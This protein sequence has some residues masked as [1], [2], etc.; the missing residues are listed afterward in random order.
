LRWW[1]QAVRRRWSEQEKLKIREKFSCRHCEKI[2][3]APAVFHAVP[4]G[5]AGQSL[6]AVIVFEKFG[7]LHPLN[8]K[9]GAPL[10]T[11]SRLRSRSTPKM[12]QAIGIRQTR[13]LLQHSDHRSNSV[14]LSDI[15][16]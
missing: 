2:S 16:N 12:K 13:M 11:A 10:W 15:R 8:R 5:S 7:Q 4:R 3:Q 14:P 6:L 1:T 9:A